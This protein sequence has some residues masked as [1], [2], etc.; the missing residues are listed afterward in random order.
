MKVTIVSFKWDDAVQDYIPIPLD[1]AEPEMITLACL[2]A[3]KDLTQD[4]F[5]STLSLLNITTE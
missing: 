2:I 4:E 1:D 3:G 5:K